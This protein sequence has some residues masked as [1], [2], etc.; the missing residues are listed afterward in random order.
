MYQVI[1]VERI[2]SKGFYYPEG[3]E[4]KVRA[5]TW[6]E[7]MMFAKYKKQQYQVDLL[8][9]LAENEVVKGIDLWE[10]TMGDWSFLELLMVTLTFR[11]ISYTFSLKCSECSDSNQREVSFRDS[12]EGNGNLTPSNFVFESSEHHLRSYIFLNGREVK[13][14]SYRLKHYR[15]IRMEG[16]QEDDY[17][18]LISLLDRETVREVVTSPID[19]PRVQSDHGLK[20][21]VTLCCSSC[22]KKEE[23]G[24]EWSVFD[25]IPEEHPDTL[26]D[27]ELELGLL[28]LQP[29][30]V[31]QKMS[32]DDVM[33]LHSRA[34]QFKKREVNGR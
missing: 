9:M 18:K 2:P 28:A 15:K 32:Y 34:Q 23:V 3:T 27:V 20:M 16:E 29:R 31:L 17:N 13:L 5:L 21:G 1:S 11:P 25:F 24:V 4:I 10:I 33:S 6:E 7:R 12:R 22:N 19:C 30:T 26:L 14:N 8:E